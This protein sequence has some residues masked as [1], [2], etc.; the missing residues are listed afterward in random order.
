MDLGS[1]RRADVSLYQGKVFVNIREYYTVRLPSVRTEVEC[2]F[3]GH[4]CGAGGNLLSLPL[5]VQLFGWWWGVCGC[6][7]VLHTQTICTHACTHVQTGHNDPPTLPSAHVVL[8]PGRQRRAQ[9]G[10][11][12]HLAAARPVLAAGLR[13]GAAGGGAAGQGHGVR[14]GAVGQVSANGVRSS[15]CV[16]VGRCVGVCGAAGAWLGRDCIHVWV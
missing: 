10:A 12:G 3:G 15:L 7:G 1:S 4:C 6:V 8:L 2:V 9:A 14:G 13:R 5:P 16:C 11:K